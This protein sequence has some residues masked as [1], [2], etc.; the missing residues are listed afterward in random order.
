MQIKLT[1]Q[2][3]LAVLLLSSKATSLF[4]REGNQVG[5]DWLYPKC[6]GLQTRSCFV[7]AQGQ[8]GICSIANDRKC[9]SDGFNTGVGDTN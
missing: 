1:L 4:H 9:S 8:L 6:H 5:A 3:W 2:D 7:D